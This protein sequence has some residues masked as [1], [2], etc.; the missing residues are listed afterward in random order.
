MKHAPAIARIMAGIPD[1]NAS[2]FRRIGVPLGDPAAWI[3]L[4]SRRIALVRDLE[5]DRVLRAGHADEVTCPGQHPPPAGLSPDRETATA[6]AVAQLLRAAKVERIHADRSL[7]YIFV[8]HLEQAEIEVLY[9]QEMGVLDRRTKTSLEIESLATAQRTTEEVMRI[10]CETIAHASAAADGTLRHAGDLLTSERIRSMAA[11]E[12]IKR[13][14]SMSHGAIVA[15]TPQV[16]DCHHCGSGPLYT[17]RPIVIDL[18]PRDETTRYWGDCSRT[19]VHGQASDT[20]K[21]M[22]RAVLEAKAT[23]ISAL[24]AGT[25][26]HA[27]HAASENVLTRHGYR[28]SRGSITDHPSI[29][30]GTGHGI[31]LDLHEPILLDFDGGEILEG[32]VFTIEPGLYGR[33]DGGIRIEDML[34]V[35]SGAA[36]NLNALPESLSW[37]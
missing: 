14:Y 35:T 13:N 7:P 28:S 30:H 27:V 1:Q 3:E 32:E 22:H 26:A 23:A 31:G 8:W 5:M 15:T 18:F 36:R 24:T 29:Q 37:D 34:V 9:D 4:D 10:V 16:A 20:V 21:A 33:H 11:Q 25:T 19:V 17:E 2:L 6:E 12:F